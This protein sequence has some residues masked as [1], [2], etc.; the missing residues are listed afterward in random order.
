MPLAFRLS[1]PAARKLL[2][3]SCYSVE[4]HLVKLFLVVSWKA[5][6]V[7][8]EELRGVKILCDKPLQGSGYT[9][10]SINLFLLFMYLQGV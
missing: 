5:D 9:E 10:I 3:V 2:S 1:V 4:K 8:V 7:P 6:Y